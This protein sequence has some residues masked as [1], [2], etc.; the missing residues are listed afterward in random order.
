MSGSGARTRASAARRASPPERARGGLVAGEAELFE[1]VARAMQ[2]VARR[3]TC[4]QICE[5]GGKARQIRLL[6]E[7]AEG[8]AG[9]REPGAAIRLDGSGRYLEQG[10]LA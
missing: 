1:Q 10:R 7:I 9:V 4:L 3:K 2:I 5:R 8:G 6:D